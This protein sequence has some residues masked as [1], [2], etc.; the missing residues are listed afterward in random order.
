MGDRWEA[1]VCG[2]LELLFRVEYVELGEKGRGHGLRMGKIMRLW[3]TAL[4]EA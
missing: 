2:G 4:E 1:P 3:K